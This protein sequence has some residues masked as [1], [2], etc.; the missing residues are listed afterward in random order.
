M[1]PQEICFFIEF[2]KVISR[3]FVVSWLVLAK[4][5]LF[6][7]YSTIAVFAVVVPVTATTDASETFL[8]AD[9]KYPWGDVM[10]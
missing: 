10:E 8:P 4:H 2:L 1:P 5:S 9:I 3:V 6:R 7:H